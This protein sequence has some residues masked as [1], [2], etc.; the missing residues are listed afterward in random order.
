VR[1]LLTT[2]HA[3]QIAEPC[4]LISG[5]AGALGG[6]WSPPVTDSAPNGAHW[7]RQVLN[8]EVLTISGGRTDTHLNMIGER[9][10][11][12]LVTPTRQQHSC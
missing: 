6:P 10:L 1:K 2:R 4:W 7:A 3:Q 11:G 9:I 12:L 8:T 5:A